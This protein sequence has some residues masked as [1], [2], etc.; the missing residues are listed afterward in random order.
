M[1]SDDKALFL[2]RDGVINI[3]HGYVGSREAFQFIDGI[4]EFCALAKELG[5]HLIVVTNQSGIG[6]GYFSEAQFTDLMTWV[7]SQFSERGLPLTGYY[8]CPFHPDA[9]PPYRRRSFMRKPAPGMLL[10]AADDHGLCLG[11]SLLIGDRASDI[12]AAKAAGLGAALLLTA[13]GRPLD[14]EPDA[15]VPDLR[16]AGDW[17]RRWNGLSRFPRQ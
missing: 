10:R 14:C 5:F 6:R 12:A 2:D 4:F 7:A 17:L 8:H 1:Q 9:K 13:A 11:R 3:D 15:V 16:R